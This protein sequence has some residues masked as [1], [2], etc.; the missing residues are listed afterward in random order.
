MLRA[1][2]SG[3]AADVT[4]TAEL[5]AQAMW[6]LAIDTYTAEAI[7]A[8][9][10][11][12]IDVLLVKGP[13]IARWLYPR[14]VRK[15]D[16]GDLL[17]APASWDRAVA[18]LQE[19][20]YADYLGPLEH[21]RMESQSGTGFRRG[22]QAIDLHSTLAGLAADPGEVWQ[23]LWTDAETQEVGGAVVRVPSRPAVLMHI[24]LH[25]AHHMMG[26]PLE[27]LSR[28]IKVAS[29]DEWR[30]AAA[31]ASG[32]GGLEAF[33]SGIRTVPQGAAIAAKLALEQAGSVGFD[34]REA[35][36]PLAEALND[37]LSASRGER[38]R[39]VM[40]ELFPNAAFMRWWMP[41]ARRG[42]VGLIASYPL[43]WLSL[44]V[45]LPA[46]AVTIYRVR[47]RRRP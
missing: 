30:A 28:A 37:L 35:R 24:A 15:Y 32:L 6:S 44:L 3:K 34:L 46:A 10:S 25:A 11:N 19:L 18:V 4:L 16:D 2:S 7:G 23:T 36:V 1:R 29:D 31:L 5:L 43:R 13:V 14:E 9:E 42:P 33:A 26:R 41:L 17:V 39:I 20:G 22:V 12:G 45:R 27:D 38:A 21:P 8:F 40:R 47:R